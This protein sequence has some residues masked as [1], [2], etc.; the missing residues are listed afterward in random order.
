MDIHSDKSS[1]LLTEAQR[2]LKSATQTSFIHSF[3]RSF[4]HNSFIHPF[5]RS[6]I[7][8]FIYHVVFLMT[9][10]NPLTKRVLYIGRSRASSSHSQYSLVFLRSP[11]SCLLLLPRLPVTSTLLILFPLTT[12][13]RRQFLRQT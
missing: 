13:F 6:F 5:I 3:I 12:C 1:L 4:I 11:S 7:H 9:G 8:S 2:K 10:P